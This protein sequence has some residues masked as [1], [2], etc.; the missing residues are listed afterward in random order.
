VSDIVI[1]KLVPSLLGD[2]LGFFDGEAS[3]DKV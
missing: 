2:R 1:R 3:A